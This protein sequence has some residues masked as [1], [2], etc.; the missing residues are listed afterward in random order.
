VLDGEEWI[1][2]GQKVW[3]TGA[4]KADFAMLL[5][6]TNWEATKHRGITFFVLD[7]RQRGV[8]VRPLR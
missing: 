2:N 8:E 3:N 4:H 5:A 7:V 6:R 1:V